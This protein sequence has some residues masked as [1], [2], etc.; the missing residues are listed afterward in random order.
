[1]IYGLPRFSL[2][3]PWFLWH[4]WILSPFPFLYCWPFWIGRPRCRCCL[5]CLRR[6]CPG[7]GGRW[8]EL[9][10]HYR[11]ALLLHPSRVDPHQFG[12]HHYSYQSTDTC[13][14]HLG[15]LHHPKTSQDLYKIKN[16][17]ITYS[18]H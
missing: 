4:S 6:V 3:A 11:T 1:M 10:L 17:F 2:F 7:F 12:T 5:T 14:H 18:Y 9:Y 8:Q 15:F 13:L 16:G